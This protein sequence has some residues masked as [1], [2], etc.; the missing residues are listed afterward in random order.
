MT[1]GLLIVAVSKVGIAGISAGA[2]IAGGVI[3]GGLGYRGVVKQMEEQRRE[4]AL[5][6]RRTAY[7]GYLSASLRFYRWARGTQTF[8]EAEWKA[9][10]AEHDAAS[11]RM[12]IL[13][14]K[15]VRATADQGIERI[16]EGWVDGR[17]R[18]AGP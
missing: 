5:E 7:A 14:S 10:R 8:G 17:D 3:G 16:F 11:A 13:G 4:A 18:E 15:S 9:L 1:D 12:E 2:A 6:Q